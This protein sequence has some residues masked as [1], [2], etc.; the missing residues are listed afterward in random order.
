MGL[1]NQPQITRYSRVDREMFIKIAK[2]W[3][4]SGTDTAPVIIG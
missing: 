4:S 3:V 2:Y 1:E